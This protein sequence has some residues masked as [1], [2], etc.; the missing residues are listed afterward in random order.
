MNSEE[1]SW[2]TIHCFLSLL[3]PGHFCSYNVQEKSF[4]DMSEGLE[5]PS[6]EG[7]QSIVQLTQPDLSPAGHVPSGCPSTVWSSGIWQHNPA[8]VHYVYL[9]SFA[10]RAREK[11]SE[12][13]RLKKTE[14]LEMKHPKSL[15]NLLTNRSFV[16][17]ES[18]NSWYKCDK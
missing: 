12:I 16:E 4:S 5:S 7:G 18:L 17:N 13:E 14:W 9:T 3:T 10:R 2:L 8:K 6:A 11:M 15:N 1:W